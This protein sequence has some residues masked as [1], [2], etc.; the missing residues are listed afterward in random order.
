VH[1]EIWWGDLREG[2]H[3]EDLGVDG[4]IILKWIFKRFFSHTP[5]STLKT[6]LC[7]HAVC[8]FFGCDFYN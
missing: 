4:R 7:S 5:P 3:L 2:D 6:A 8:I 1:T